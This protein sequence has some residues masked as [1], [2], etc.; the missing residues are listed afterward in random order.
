MQNVSSTEQAHD[1]VHLRDQQLMKLPD[2]DILA[3]ARS[4]GRVVLTFDLDFGD[5]LAAAG[6][7]LPSVV[8]FR[9]RNQT[10]SAVNP[11]LFSVISEC[12]DHLERGAIIVVEETH[13]RIRHLPIS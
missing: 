7:N 4:E 8:I 10:P 9:L 5:L 6:Q 12:R 2:A 3:K 13:Y 11:R 1:V